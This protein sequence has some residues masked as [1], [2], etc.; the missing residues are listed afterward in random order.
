MGAQPDTST[1]TPDVWHGIQ[2]ILAQIPVAAHLA[3]YLDTATHQLTYDITFSGFSSDVVAAHIHGP[4]KAGETA[5]V[6]VPLGTAPKSPIHGSTT[7]TLEQ[8]K[9]LWD[10]LWYVNVHTKNHPNG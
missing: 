3:T 2:Q 1:S 6:V 7:L 5:G 9:Q 8:E 10:G 4:A